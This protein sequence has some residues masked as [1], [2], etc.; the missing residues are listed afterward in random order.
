MKEKMFCYQCQ[1]TA[2][3]TGCL[4]RGVCG[5]T[6]NVAA[7][8]DLLIF[9]VKGLSIVASCLDKKMSDSNRKTVNRFVCDALFSTITNTNFN[10]EDITDRIC[11]GIDLRNALLN[12]AG[13]KGVEVPMVGEVMWNAHRDDCAAKARSVGILAETDEDKRSLGQLII[14]G[15][16]GIAAYLDH[17]MRLGHDDEDIHHFI[18]TTLARLSLNH[19]GKAELLRIVNQV[20]EYGFKAMALLDRANTS[21]FGHPIPTHVNL[22]TVHRPGILISGH[23]L[24]DI[25]MLLEQSEGQGVDIY[26]HGEMLPAHYYPA[27]RKYSHFVGN[28]GSSWWKQ[29]EEFESF[30]GPILFTSNCIVPP[31]EGASYSQKV[32]TTNSA[33]YPGWRHI[34]AD[35]NGKKDFTEIINEARRCRPPRQIERGSIIGGFAHNQIGKMADK[36]VNAVKN[37]TIRRFVVMAGCDGRMNSRNYYTEY[38]RNLPADTVILTAGCAKYRY[39]K[40]GLGEID[41]ISRILDAGQ[42]N[43]CYSLIVT[44]LKLKEIMQLNNINELPITYNLAWYEQKAVI[45]LLTLLNLGIKDICIGPT[46]PAFLSPCVR[47]ILTEQYGLKTI[48]E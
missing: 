20:G 40:L 30:G 21:S 33:S 24:S 16:K 23:D 19:M 36:I 46:L 13:Q 10:Y 31:F 37:G 5:K 48:E 8:M 27:F 6:P 17:A 41:G 29:R 44:A 25:Q 26:T 32:F 15:L 28:Y 38:A 2:H 3:N 14:Y 7:A 11:R 22:G 35:S 39:I 42:C 4:V 45:V 47:R 34:T 12:E 1:E 18:R 43:D 9:V